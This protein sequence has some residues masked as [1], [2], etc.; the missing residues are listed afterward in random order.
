M[1]AGPGFSNVG[2]EFRETFGDTGAQSGLH[3]GKGWVG[4][5]GVILVLWADC[6]LC[7]WKASPLWSSAGA[8]REGTFDLWQVK[9]STVDCC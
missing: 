5:P 1:R 4:C 3:G 7:S 2:H 9:S 8:H 6:Q